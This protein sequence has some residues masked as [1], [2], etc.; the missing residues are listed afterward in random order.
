MDNYETRGRNISS[1][2]KLNITH[3]YTK[4]IQ[5]MYML[6]QMLSI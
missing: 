4:P 2:I 5:F 6:Y 3:A 1:V